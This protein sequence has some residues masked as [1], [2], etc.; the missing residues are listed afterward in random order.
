M[1]HDINILYVDD[2]LENL[3]AF[4]STLRREFNVFIAISADEALKILNDRE[5][6]ILL[7]D[8]K[9][10]ET[11]GIDLLQQ[12]QDD[13]PNIIR[14]LISAYADYETAIESIHKADVFRFLTKPWD[15]EIL[16]RVILEGAELYSL[17]A[18]K[19]TLFEQYLGLFNANPTP[20]II[21]ALDT[22]NILQVN[23]AA[24]QLL[25]PVFDLKNAPINELFSIL[26]QSEASKDIGTNLKTSQGEIIVGLRLKEIN[27]KNDKAILLSIEN[28]SKR[29]EEA[30]KK[31]SLITEI[32]QLEREK[33]SME[34]HDGIAQ[35]IV[36]LKLCVERQAA[37][38]NNDQSYNECQSIIN[39]LMN[40]IRALSYNLAPPSLSE[41]FIT[42]IENVLQKLQRVTNL[43]FEISIKDKNCEAFLKN[44]NEDVSYDIF[45]ICQEF[46]NNAIT[47][48]ETERI[49]I[50]ID[51]QANEY[52]LTILDTGNGFDINEIS[53]GNGLKNMRKRADLHEIKFNLESIKSNGTKLEL[54]FPENLFIRLPS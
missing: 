22:K 54:I 40:N 35:D 46:I 4:K 19:Q 15:L 30:L 12:V 31:K 27:Y 38:K 26:D 6:H 25:S 10:P 32:Q 24:E 16:K 1:N 11:T 39:E 2:E 23:E 20:L 42:A 21:Y 14:M 7:S 33:F 17:K 13:Y 37:K 51:Q 53:K 29:I 52:V 18:E 48:G 44:I 49:E 34:L 41:G 36:L 3:K 8:Q 47:H 45:R 5:I 50:S 28:Q 9:M 43:N